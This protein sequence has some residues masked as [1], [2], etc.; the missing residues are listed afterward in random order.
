M[1]NTKL[2]MDKLGQ[3]PGWRSLLV[4]M[5]IWTF[6]MGWQFSHH[7]QVVLFLDDNDSP[8]KFSVEQRSDA[9]LMCAAA[10]L[11]QREATSLLSLNLLKT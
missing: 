9:R 1:C 10:L 11:L 3:S 2:I 5:P 4:V 6:N 8:R 7:V